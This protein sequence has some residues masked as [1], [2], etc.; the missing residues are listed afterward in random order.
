MSFLIG[1]VKKLLFWITGFL[2][3]FLLALFTKYKLFMSILLLSILPIALKWTYFLIAKEFLDFLSQND[4]INFSK[5]DASSLPCVFF[6]LAS[7]F[8]MDSVFSIMISA[9]TIVLILRLVRLGK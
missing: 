5:P 8:R 6:Y 3:E 2:P 7:Q 4:N 9:Y 1:A